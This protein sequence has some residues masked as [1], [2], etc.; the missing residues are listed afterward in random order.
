MN[1]KRMP[2]PTDIS[3]QPLFREEVLVGRRNRLCGEVVLSQ[4]ISAEMIVFGIFA[5]VVGALV[6]LSRASGVKTIRWEAIDQSIV[7]TRPAA[8]FA[9]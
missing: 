6:W 1:N 8:L 2:L 4:S 5:I 9:D 3:T 7:R